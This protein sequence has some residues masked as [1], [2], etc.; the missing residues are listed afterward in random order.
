MSLQE[1]RIEIDLFTFTQKLL[2]TAGEYCYATERDTEAALPVATLEHWWKSS[3]SDTTE[4]VLRDSFAM[5][6]H[7]R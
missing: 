2:Q 7:G 1:Y 6:G 3:D 4:P 5:T